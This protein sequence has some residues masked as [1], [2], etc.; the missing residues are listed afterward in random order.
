MC[1][2]TKVP[3]RV[4]SVAGS[5]LTSGACSTVQSGAKA[6]SPPGLPGRNMFQAKRL[7]QARVDTT[8]TAIR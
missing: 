6:A 2:T 3:V 8:R 7:A 1:S 4:S 5:A